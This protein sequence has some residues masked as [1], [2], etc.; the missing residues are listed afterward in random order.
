M[1]IL[2]QCSKLLEGGTNLILVTVVKASRGT[3]GKEGFKMILTDQDQLFGTVGGGAIEH[4]A[5]QDA[6]EVQKANIFLC[7]F[8]CRHVF[9][10]G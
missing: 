7:R 6:K 10:F 5:V 1:E 9:N 3:P 8:G 2:R 4:R